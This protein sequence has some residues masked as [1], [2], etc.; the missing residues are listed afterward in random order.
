VSGALT[1]LGA[2]FV[3]EAEWE[4]A[5]ASEA[6]EATGAGEPSGPRPRKGSFAANLNAPMDLHRV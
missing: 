5:E 6:I 3:G 2:R 1:A 4:G